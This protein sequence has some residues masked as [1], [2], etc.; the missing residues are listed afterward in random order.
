MI[1]FAACAIAILL[2]G[3]RAND[4]PRPPDKAVDRERIG[5]LVVEMQLPDPERAAAA[6]RELA[7]C[8]KEAAPRL[9]GLAA[10]GS[11]AVAVQALE[12]LGAIGSEEAIAPICSI[13]TT[14]AHE[15]VRLAAA[16]ALLTFASPIAIDPIGAALA[17]E[18][19]ADVRVACLRALRATPDL[20]AGRKA[21]PSLQDP[22]EMVRSAAVDVVEAHRPEGAGDALAASCAWLPSSS[23]WGEKERILGILVAWKDP[24]AM[25]LLRDALSNPFSS[26]TRQEAARLLGEL[27]DPRAVSALIEAIVDARPEVALAAH[28]SLSKLTGREDPGAPELGDANGRGAVRDAWKRWIEERR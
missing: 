23:A 21:L 28:S 3:C 8:G 22:A 25:P 18:R 12:V 16:D 1:R 4:A 7:L 14:S 19:C 13:L 20:A 27:G 26:P 15:T 5:R 9:I 6:R 17:R 11:P 24:Q 2:T 10:S